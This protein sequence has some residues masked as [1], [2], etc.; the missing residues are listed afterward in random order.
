MKLVDNLIR[1]VEKL[2]RGK[3]RDRWIENQLKGMAK[4]GAKLVL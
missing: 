1:S 4:L 2:F 3:G